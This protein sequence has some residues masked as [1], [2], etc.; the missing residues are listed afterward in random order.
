MLFVPDFLSPAFFFAISVFAVQILVLSVGMVDL[1]RD[2]NSDNKYKLPIDVD[3]QIS[4][5]QFISLLSAAVTQND[6]FTSLRGACSSFV[7]FMDGRVF[8]G[9]SCPIR[10][11]SQKMFL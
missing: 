9:G 7:K 4:V 6:S 1:K 11:G 2:G 3:V 10:S 8:A 5:A